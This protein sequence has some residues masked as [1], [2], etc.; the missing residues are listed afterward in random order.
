M[1]AKSG[2]EAEQPEASCFT[3][4]FAKSWTKWLPILE[5]SAAGL[6]QLM[7]DLA[8]LGPGDKVLD[9]ATGAGDPALAAARA[10]APDGEVLAVDFSSEMLAYARKR[11]AQ[12]GLSNLAFTEMDADRL[13]LPADAFD[14]VLSRW[15]LMFVKDLPACL[16]ALNRCLKPGG[17]LVA[18][19]W[20]KPAKVPVIELGT[21][22]LH[23]ELGLAPPQWGAGTPFS[24]KDERAFADLLT[25]AGFAAIRRENVVVVYRFPVAA[26]YLAF[27]R[28]RMAPEVKFALESLSPR[29]RDKVWQTLEAELVP[30]VGADG[31]LVMANSAYCLAGRKPAGNEPAG[32]EPAGN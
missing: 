21:R 15:G 8:G 24:L 22:I 2:N 29:E 27:R 6:D 26:D 23:R 9:V 13:D 11:A 18:A 30:M 28:E 10:V 20:E 25:A 1:N 17:F 4:E 14:A 16:T 5:K 7:I 31:S 32:N 19:V 3:P 12:A